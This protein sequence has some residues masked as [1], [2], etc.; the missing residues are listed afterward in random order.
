[1]VK[2]IRTLLS[3]ISQKVQTNSQNCVAL[4][5]CLLSE[6]LPYKKCYSLHRASERVWKNAKLHSIAPPSNDRIPKG[7]Y[8]IC[9]TSDEVQNIAKLCGTTPPYNIRTIEWPAP[10]VWFFTAQLVEHSISEAMALNPVEAPEISFSG[11]IR[12]SSN[13]DFNCD[14]RIFSTISEAM[15]FDRIQVHGSLWHNIVSALT[16]CA[17]S[18]GGLEFAIYSW[19]FATKFNA[20]FRPSF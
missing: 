10:N 8:S 16:K 17:D 5:H 4:H 14:G 9:K 12:N 18:S 20:L 19:L 15:P 3:V 13:C 1:M 7:W 6:A 11:S 2:R